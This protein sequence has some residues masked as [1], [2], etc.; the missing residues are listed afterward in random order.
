MDY[1][2]RAV[3]LVYRTNFLIFREKQTVKLGKNSTF[4][5]FFLKKRKNVFLF[6][7]HLDMPHRF[8]VSLLFYCYCLD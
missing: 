1:V 3:V 8:H 2:T 5:F 7:N 6:V 4:S